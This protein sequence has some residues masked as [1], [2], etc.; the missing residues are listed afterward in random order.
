MG[1]LKIVYIIISTLFWLAVFS[2][3][4]YVAGR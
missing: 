4:L 1:S 3:V 2:A